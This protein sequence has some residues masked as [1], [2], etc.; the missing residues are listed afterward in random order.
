MYGKKPEVVGFVDINPTE[1][2][3]WMYCPIRLP[4]DDRLT[5]PCDNLNIFKEIVHLSEIDFMDRFGEGTLNDHYVY[6]TVKTMFVNAE[7]PGNRPGWHSDGFMTDDIN[8][9]WSDK[10]PTVFWEP[11]DHFRLNPP[12]DHTESLA[13]FNEVEDYD[14]EHVRYPNKTLLMLDQYVIHKVDTNIQPGY[15]T[16]VKVSFSK[17]KYNLVGNSINHNLATDWEYV[18]RTKERNHPIG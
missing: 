16:F 7:N 5:L 6:L 12:H 15:R 10:N 17:H 14:N 3:Y 2:M 9:V 11:E 18:E 8:Y 4:G 1:M 13:L